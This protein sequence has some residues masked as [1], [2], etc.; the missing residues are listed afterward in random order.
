MVTSG[1]EMGELGNAFNSMTR[2]LRANAERLEEQEQENERM[3]L[4]KMPDL[5][6]RRYQRGDDAIAEFHSNVTLLFAHIAGFIDLSS[7]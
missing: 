4:N 7:Q 5:V 6:A 3:L 1:D 2:S